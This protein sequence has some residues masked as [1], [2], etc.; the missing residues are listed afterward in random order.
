MTQLNPLLAGRYQMGRLLG[1]G[2]FGTV[3]F[4]TDERLHRPVAIKICSTKR[5]PPHEAT[6]AAQLFQSEALTLARLRHAGLTAIWDYFNDGDDWYLVMEYVPGETLRDVLRKSGG[7]LPQADAISYTRQLC[8]VLSHLAH[9]KR[10]G[11]PRFDDPSNA[12][13]VEPN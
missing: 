10:S 9:P 8:S 5:L 4:A 13:V 7:A 11:H 3:Y 6:E 12:L 1:S 2:G